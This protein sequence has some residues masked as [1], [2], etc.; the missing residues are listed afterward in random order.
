LVEFI[1]KLIG[2]KW[3]LTNIYAPCTADGKLDFLSWFKN[4]GMPDSQSWIIM[5][6]FNLIRKPENRNKAGGDNSMMMAFNDAI[7][8]LEII[9]LPLYGQEFA[10][11]N[12]QQHPL[13]ER[14][15]WFFVSHAWSLEFPGTLV[16]TLTR[17]FR[18]CPL[19]S[20]N[21][22]RGSQA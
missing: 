6:D 4:I 3:I 21:Q 9:E 1:S 16:Q 10:W 12:K 19:C 18:P 8:K 17:D 7:R 14:L 13:L 2:Q 5:G 20:D 15:D 11:T 22:N